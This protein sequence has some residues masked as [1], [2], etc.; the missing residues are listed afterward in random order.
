MRILKKNNEKNAS[1]LQLIQKLKQ[2]LGVTRMPK[3][4]HIFVQLYID[5]YC[6]CKSQTII[7]A[8]KSSSQTHSLTLNVY[9]TGVC[10]GG[11][12]GG[13]RGRG[14]GTLNGKGRW[15]SAGE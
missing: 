15:R 10:M 13:G 3:S 7:Q 8:S 4:M 5:K 2:N 9:W 6:R 11:W 12:G 1:C 14:A